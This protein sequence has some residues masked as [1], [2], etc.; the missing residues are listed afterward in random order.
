MAFSIT[1]EKT[2]IDFEIVDHIYF[3]RHCLI[4]HDLFQVTIRVYWAL[5]IIR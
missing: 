3:L 5:Y 1:E 2:G 4:I